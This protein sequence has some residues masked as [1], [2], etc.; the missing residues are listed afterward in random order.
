MYALYYKQVGLETTEEMCSDI[1][2]VET[3]PKKP[4]GWYTNLQGKLS[5]KVVK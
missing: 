3:L 4:T 1:H 2:V 5:D